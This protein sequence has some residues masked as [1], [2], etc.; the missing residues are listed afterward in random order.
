MTWSPQAPPLPHTRVDDPTGVR[1][2]DAATLVAIFVA[3]LFLLPAKLV[4]SRLP[5]SISAATIVA[6]GLGTF[7]MCTQL[8]TTLGAAKGR[9]PVRTALLAHGF[10]LLLSF[11]GMSVAYLPS[12]ERA[13]GDHAMIT[14]FALIFV[15]L[16]VCDGVVT[17]E[18]LYFLIRVIVGCAC[19]VALVGILQYLFKFD[20]TPHLKPPLMRFTAEDPVVLTRGGL[21]R[22]SGTTAHPIEYGVF[23]AMVLPLALHLTTFGPDTRASRALRWAAV[24]LLGTGLMFSVSR[25]AIVALL[26]VATVLAVG[27]SPERRVRMLTAGA[28]FLV[29]VGVF[30]PS[31]LRTLFNLFRGAGN[32][33]SVEWRTHDYATA[34]QLIS[35]HLLLGRG[36]GTWYPPKHE[37]FDNQYLLTLVGGGVIGLVA[38]LSIFVA[39]VYAAFRVIRLSS[40]SAPRIPLARRDRDLALSVMAS[41]TVVFPSFATF[42]FMGF[43]KVASLAFLLA[44]LAGALLRVVLREAGELS[45][46]GVSAAGTER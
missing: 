19:F 25:S 44:G 11:W 32:D 10:A 21:P 27:W 9:S 4:M 12:D 7:W 23:C 46:Y 24:V 15:A 20:L 22:V 26:C 36:I 8:T 5:L 2:A 16:V 31:I 28:G 34:R 41:L 30:T 38:L 35:E 42:D 18:R 3:L 29:A 1:S 43:A 40:G 14:A 45:G 37:I 33:G 17:R 6:L 39:G 13:L